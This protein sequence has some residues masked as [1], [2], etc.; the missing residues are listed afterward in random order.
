MG[1]HT[2]L[3]KIL[4]NPGME[5]HLLGLL[6]YRQILYCWTTREACLNP[7]DNANY[8]QLLTLPTYEKQKD[9][10]EQGFKSS[11]YYPKNDFAIT[12]HAANWGNSKSQMRMTYLQIIIYPASWPLFMLFPSPETSL[13]PPP[14]SKVSGSQGSPLPGSLPWLSFPAMK[15]WIASDSNIYLMCHHAL[16]AELI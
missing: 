5:L 11:D 6:Y 2:L 13:V 12:N 3:Q 9:N 10:G 8:G 1:C 7:V 14:P 4:P 16:P 15:F